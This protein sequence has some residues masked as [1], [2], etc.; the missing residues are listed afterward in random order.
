MIG[1]FA[2]SCGTLLKLDT[3]GMIQVK[4]GKI[5]PTG[6][7]WEDFWKSLQLT[8]DE[9]RHQVIAKVRMTLWVRWTNNKE[10]QGKL[11]VKTLK[12]N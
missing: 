6:F 4:L 7:R 1:W 9:H 2:L 12:N 5:W 11:K 3:I 8:A 10:L